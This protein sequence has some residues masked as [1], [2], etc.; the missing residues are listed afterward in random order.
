[1]R[2]P[3]FFTFALLY[4]ATGYCC[5]QSLGSPDLDLVLSSEISLSA[6]TCIFADVLILQDK[7]NITNNGHPLKIAAGEL[8]IVGGAQIQGFDYGVASYASTVSAPAAQD[9]PTAMPSWDKGPTNGQGLGRDGGKFSG[10]SVPTWASSGTD[11]LSPGDIRIA[12]SG[13][14]SGTL[15][16]VGTGTD[17]Q[18][19]SN[20]S[21][22]WSGGD[23]EQGTEG[24]GNVLCSAGPGRGGTGGNGSTGQH[25]GRGGRGGNGASIEI[26]VGSPSPGFSVRANIQPGRP[27]APGLPGPGG[28]PGLQGCGGRGGPC[29]SKEFERQG[30]IGVPGIAGFLG[31]PGDNGKIGSIAK[32]GDFDLLHIGAPASCS[33][34]SLSPTEKDLIDKQAQ[35]SFWTLAGYRLLGQTFRVVKTNDGGK[36][37]VINPD[38]ANGLLGF[39][40]PAAIK[41]YIASPPPKPGPLPAGCQGARCCVGSPSVE[42]LNSTLWKL[43]NNPDGVARYRDR[44]LWHRTALDLLH[45]ELSALGVAMPSRATEAGFLETQNV[46]LDLGQGTY[47]R[48]TDELFARLVATLALLLP[49][50]KIALDANVRPEFN[51]VQCNAGTAYRVASNDSF[52]TRPTQEFPELKPDHNW[53]AVFAQSSLNGFNLNSSVAQQIFL[54]L[55]I[56]SFR[57]ETV[58]NAPIIETVANKD[59]WGGRPGFHAGGFCQIFAT[60][61]LTPIDAPLNCG[62]QSTSLMRDL[63]SRWQNFDTPSLIFIINALLYIDATTRVNYLDLSASS[64]SPELALHCL[65]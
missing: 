11:G 27:G 5:D 48:V 25:A 64:L 4:P 32:S 13:S 51:H 7:T 39:A 57:S 55:P 34:I 45:I 40:Q 31:K 65:R 20:G 62:G 37:L 52:F 12:V 8:R 23:G 2:I 53:N 58:L 44:R 42:C 56:A 35:F 18:R 47:L 14:A 38:W 60:E 41:R 54:I 46:Y 9:K 59:L 21:R 63:R 15:T 30:Y 36:A 29:I 24:Q 50:I 16:I 22:G 49:S 17:G 61:N 19:G 28:R 33:P 26:S 3:L 43:A 6:S 1:M 10:V